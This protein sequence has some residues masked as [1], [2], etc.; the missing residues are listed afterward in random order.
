M[1]IIHITD[2]LMPHAGGLVSVPTNLAAA[3]ANLGHDTVI[4]GRT[5]TRELEAS[6]ETKNIP[7]F[8]K[9][10]IVDCNQPGGFIS[11]ILPIKT[12]PRIWQEISGG[13]IVHLH[14]TWDPMLYIATRIARIRGIPYIM[15]PHSM[16]HP[17]QMERYVWQKKIVF[18]IGWRKMFR[19]AAFMHALNE[20]E[21]NYIEQFAF[22]SPI[23]ILPNGVCAPS[24]FVDAT[25]A[26]LEDHPELKNHPYIL[27]LSRLHSQKGTDKLLDAFELFHQTN[28]ECRLVVAGPDYGERKNMEKRLQ[29]MTARE[30]VHMVGPLYGGRKTGALREACC[31]IQP[32]RNEGFSISILEALSYGLPSVITKN[33]FFDEVAHSGSGIVTDGSPEELSEALLAITSDSGTRTE[34]SRNARNLIQQKYSWT[35]IAKQSIR[36]YEN[37]QGA[38]ARSS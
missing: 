16:F 12:P 5:G 23:E 31:F 35:E 26:F 24:L 27:F 18:A 33:C 2:E 29:S 38:S 14:G 28:K 4:L 13:S 21:K 9:V 7:G 19:Q 37:Y 22:G 32:S 8:D 6:N 10:R 25:N 34:M 20:A 15:T 36:L 30:C 17:W 11:K 3:Q 1:K